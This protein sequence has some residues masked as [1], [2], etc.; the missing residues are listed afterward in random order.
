[1]PRS[2]AYLLWVQTRVRIAKSG[3]DLKSLQASM[4]SRSTIAGDENSLSGAG[5][6]GE[7]RPAGR[8]SLRPRGVRARVHGFDRVPLPATSACSWG[9]GIPFDGRG[10]AA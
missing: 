6:V 1:M 5:L 10:S 7:P 2:G 4:S 3:V 9:H 8:G